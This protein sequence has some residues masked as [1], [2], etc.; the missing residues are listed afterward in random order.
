MDIAVNGTRLWFDVEGAG[1]VPDGP[2]MRRR[3]TVVLIHG[4]PAS[5]DHSYFKPAFAALTRSAQ[6]VYLDL[7]DHGRSAR[8]D[9]AALTVETCADDIR[10][11]CDALGIERPVVLGH[12]FGGMVVLLYG[13]RHPG[14]AGGLVLQS[15]MAR[16]DLDRLVEGFRRLGGDEVAELARRAYGDEPHI[17]DAQWSRVFAVFGP[18]VPDAEVLVRRIGN[19]TL[20]EHGDSLL[21]TFDGVDQ[22]RRIASPT[23]VSVGAL[24]A[25]TPVEASQEIAEHLPAGIGRLSVLDGAGHFPWLDTPEAYFAD[26]SG[27]IETATA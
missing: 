19:E 24:D 7:R 3:P 23:L 20:G 16:F 12:S 6:V 14:H 27:F 13:A 17:T 1:L 15:T 2:V 22:L 4:G 25:V 9:P 8:G 26:L 5:Y 18:H 11:F 21:T 10:A